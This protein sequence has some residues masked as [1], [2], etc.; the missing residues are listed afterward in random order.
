MIAVGVDGVNNKIVFCDGTIDNPS[1]YRVLEIDA[2]EET[3][4]SEKRN[5]IYAFERQGIQQKA[6]GIFKVHTRSDVRTQHVRQRNGTEAVGYNNQLGAGRGRGGKTARRVKEIRFGEDG[7][8][9]SR[10]YETNVRRALGETV[11]TATTRT[12]ATEAVQKEKAP[13]D[14]RT[15]YQRETEEINA[16]ARERLGEVYTSLS[17]PNKRII[18][19]IIRTARANGMSDA[20]AF[21]LARVSAHSGVDIVITDKVS[22]DGE[23]RLS[24]KKIYIN[25]K[26]TRSAAR[27]LSHEM[28]H[29]VYDYFGSRK[30]FDRMIQSAME[31][32][33]ADRTSRISSAYRK[34]GA[35]LEVIQ[36]EFASHFIE[37]FANED[38]MT[39]LTARKPGIK[40]KIISFFTGAAKAY[41]SEE[42]LSRAARKYLKL[43]RDMFAKMSE[44]RS[45]TNAFEVAPVTSTIQEKMQVRG[46][47]GETSPAITNADVDTDT[48]FALIG[49]TEDGRGIYRTNYPENTPKD[50]KQKDIV[51]LVQNVW[52][53]KPI[54]LNLIIDGKTVPIEARFNPELTERS[55]LSK[56][57][58]GNR[59]GTASEKRITMNLSSDLYQIAEESHHVGSKTES[60]KDNATHA[61]VTT[62]HYFLTDLV[63]VEADGTE[64][65]C[66]MNIDVK[67]NDSGHWFYSFAI[68]KGSR[69]ADV[70]SVVT[71]KSA[72]TSTISIT[73]NAEKSNPSGE[74]SSETS[75]N[76]RYALTDNGKKTPGVAGADVRYAIRY[77][78]FSDADISRNMH[79]IADMDAVATIDASKLEK[80][81]KSPMDTF[82]EYF[83]SLGNN[84][85]SETFGDIAL[86]KSSAKSEIRHGITAEKIA[87]I[88]AIPAVIEQGKVIFHKAKEGGVERIVVCAPIKIGEADY[89]MGVMLQR[90][91]RYQRLYL[92]N[93]VSVAIEREATSSSKDNLVTTGALENENHLSITSIIQKALNVKAEKQKTAIKPVETFSGKRY[94]IPETRDDSGDIYAK[95]I[96]PFL[97][98][99]FATDSDEDKFDVAA[100]LE[101]GPPRKPGTATLT[102]GEMKKFIANHTHNKVFS[103]KT[104]LEVIGKMSGISDLSQKTRAELAD[105]L[106]QGFNDCTDAESRRIFAHDMA[107]FIVAK[108]I[109]EAKTENPD[110]MEAQERLSYLSTYIGRISFH[111]EYIDEI[112]HVVDREGLKKILGRWGYK[113]KNGT[114]RVPMDVF[115]CDISREMPGMSAS[116]ARTGVQLKHAL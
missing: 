112:R 68:E 63:Y 16:Q 81:G 60:G 26:G 55:D 11:D 114:Q 28:F 64:I 40:D 44:S 77:P 72:T 107:E 4:L 85:A 49:R 95:D 22:A 41:K 106:W 79:A 29:A 34:H 111:R 62:W 86:P 108:M 3:T 8:E 101:Y 50:V 19:K 2:H 23:Y 53:K 67:Q 5:E 46:E 74:N 20:D 15:R 90:D 43:Y 70:L 59:K 102:V 115:V 92:H 104:A 18:R 73:E 7:Q 97:Q 12:E 91:A 61:G 21:M 96:L 113:G 66:Y 78:S 52:S 89:Y 36:E 14:G 99:M 33:G 25:P 51:D 94:A 58:F 6:G 110:V 54:K 1:I 48:R 88:E 42:R 47:N 35:S 37:H 105:A 109:T 71:D 87:S 84:I 45:G 75:S 82:N 65:E 57:A 38:F 76:E 30:E 17:E 27:V 32:L 116:R 100:I 24:T 80:T 10:S 83:N 31:G 39:E 103:K 9:I 56:I 69:P 13:T 93:V 98:D